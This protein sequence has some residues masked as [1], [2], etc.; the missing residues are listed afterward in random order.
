MQVF[1]VPTYERLLEAWEG[2]YALPA[3]LEALGTML[4]RRLGVPAPDAKFSRRRVTRM[5]GRYQ[6]GTVLNYDLLEEDGQTYWSVG[7]HLHELAHH[8]DHRFSLGRNAV[9]EAARPYWDQL[10]RAADLAGAD[11]Y[12]GPHQP[13]SHGPRFYLACQ[14]VHRLAQRYLSTLKTGGK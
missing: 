11:Y 1:G 4:C 13:K 3:D 14:M 5:S 7:T 6:C 9:G 2:Q 12:T 8:V 10:Q